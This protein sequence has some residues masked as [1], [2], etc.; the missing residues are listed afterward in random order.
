MHGRFTA[1]ERVL[2]QRTFTATVNESR[3]ERPG[4]NLL[5]AFAGIAQFQ[6]HDKLAFRHHR[7]VTP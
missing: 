4:I 6:F 3:T 5:A 7:W 2:L 1:R